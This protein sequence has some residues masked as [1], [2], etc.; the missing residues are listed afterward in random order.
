MFQASQ[1]HVLVHPMSLRQGAADG[2]QAS[3][4]S[5]QSALLAECYRQEASQLIQGDVY[6]VI[7]DPQL[8]QV[9]PKQPYIAAY[10]K[11]VAD[12]RASVESKGGYFVYIESSKKELGHY[13]NAGLINKA[14]KERGVELAQRAQC[15]MFGDDVFENVLTGGVA[16]FDGFNLK[17][18][19]TVV[20]RLTNI[21]FWKM[22]NATQFEHLKNLLGK[23]TIR[24]DIEGCDYSKYV[25]QE[26]P[27]LT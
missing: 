13:K 8:S 25:P 21:L 23:K 7:G 11:L 14:L 3:I 19:P 1:L 12:L 4:A 26:C 2:S 10:R 20:A 9:G 24:F 15:F 16:V 22:F 17:G 27:E 5:I 6:C 18:K